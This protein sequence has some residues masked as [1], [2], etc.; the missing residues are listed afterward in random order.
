MRVHEIIFLVWACIATVLALAGWLAYSLDR[1]MHE[2]ELAKIDAHLA[3]Q[4]KAWKR[5]LRIAGNMQTIGTPT[6]AP[7][8]AS[9]VIDAEERVQRMVSE[10]TIARGVERLRAEYARANLGVPEDDVLRSEVLS[11]LGGN[12]P[13]IEML[14]LPRD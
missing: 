4:V 8:E 1:Q 12:E 6:P 3:D 13:T 7:V 14:T 9:R 10:Q 2:R 5:V 11:M